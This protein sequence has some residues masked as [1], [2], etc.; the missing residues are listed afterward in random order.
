[1]VERPRTR[2]RYNIFCQRLHHSTPFCL[3]WT[4]NGWPFFTDSRVRDRRTIQ[5]S[6]QV[7]S[8]WRMTWIWMDY[9]SYC[10]FVGLSRTTRLLP[11]T[12]LPEKIDPWRW[13]KR[14]LDEKPKGSSI[15]DEKDP[16]C[17][18]KRSSLRDPVRPLEHWLKLKFKNLW[19]RDASLFKPS[20]FCGSTKIYALC[21]QLKGWQNDHEKRNTLVTRFVFNDR[22]RCCSQEV[23]EDTF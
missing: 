11:E 3:A 2:P 13:T 12:I 6:S 16:P 21:S 22:C 23:Y 19:R 18:I 4:Y 10:P 8:S 15:R 5:A 9:S 1:M 7:R 17:G 20:M 14:I